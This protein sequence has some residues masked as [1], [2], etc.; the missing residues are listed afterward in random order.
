MS[1]HNWFNMISFQVLVLF[2]PVSMALL[3][4]RPALWPH[5]LMIFLGM[6]T[7]MLSVRTDDMGVLFFLLMVFGFF[8]GFAQPGQAW[9]CAFLLAMWIPVAEAAA[10]ATGV[11]HGSPAG[12]LNSLVAFIPALLGAGL[13]VLIHRASQT[14]RVV[15]R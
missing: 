11:T 13:G 1:H 6:M 9:V 14:Q 7:G 8:G 15:T 5:C 2:F 3:W 10:L 4:R 12:I